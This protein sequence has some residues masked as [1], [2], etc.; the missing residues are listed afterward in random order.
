MWILGNSSDDRGTQLEVLTADLL[1]A[2]EYTNI[3]KNRVGP[4]GE[5]I[6]ITAEYTR[7]TFAGSHTQKLMCECKAYKTRVDINHWL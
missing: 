7:Q 3:V 2:M 4:G 5:E 1:T 6:D